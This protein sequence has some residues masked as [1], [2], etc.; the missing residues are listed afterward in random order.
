MEEAGAGG[1]GGAAAPA[2]AELLADGEARAVVAAG[3]GGPRGAGGSAW[4]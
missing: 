3:E 1:G 2:L 4:L